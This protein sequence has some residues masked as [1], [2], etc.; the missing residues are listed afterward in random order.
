MAEG[1]F[2]YFCGVKKKGLAST[3]PFQ[4]LVANQELALTASKNKL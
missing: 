1:C 2:S 3:K 4:N